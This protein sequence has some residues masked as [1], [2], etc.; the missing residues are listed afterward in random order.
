MDARKTVGVILLILLLVCVIM[1]VYNQSYVS[2]TL[3]DASGST[4]SASMYNVRDN[5][6][7]RAWKDNRKHGDQWQTALW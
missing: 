2:Y 6:E 7:H 5:E 1:L 3:T 4:L